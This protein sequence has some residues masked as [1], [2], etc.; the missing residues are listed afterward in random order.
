V[1]FLDVDHLS[2]TLTGG[3]SEFLGRYGRLRDPDAMGRA[4]LSGRLGAGLDPG[5]AT[6]AAPGNC[7]G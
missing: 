2:R 1:A 5:S 4:R 3:R 7:W 6:A